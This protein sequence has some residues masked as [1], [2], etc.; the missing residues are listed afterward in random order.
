MFI[1]EF[2]SPFFTDPG[3]TAGFTVMGCN[4]SH[5]R[6]FFRRCRRRRSKKDEANVTPKNDM[7]M[8]ENGHLYDSGNGHNQD[9]LQGLHFLGSSTIRNSAT[10]PFESGMNESP[11]C[12]PLLAQSEASSSQLD[13]F[14]MLDEKIAEGPDYDPEDAKVE[15]EIHRKHLLDVW[16]KGIQSFSFSRRDSESRFTRCHWDEEGD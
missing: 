1:L 14:K 16:S 4:N 8:I 13:F 6:P 7:V 11:F 12:V 5:L 2:I 10:K 15:Y 9:I 3:N